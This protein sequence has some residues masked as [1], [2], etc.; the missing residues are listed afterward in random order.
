MRGSRLAS[1]LYIIGNQEEYRTHEVPN[2]V[3]NGRRRV[4]TVVYPSH[5]TWRTSE[6]W[7][8][9]CLSRTKLE[10]KRIGNQWTYG[11][12]SGPIH[13]SAGTNPQQHAQHNSL[14]LKRGA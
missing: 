14:N 9:G 10:R 3:H 5:S 11:W 6:C 4:A 1:W 8:I 13:R 7:N 12:A 2:Y